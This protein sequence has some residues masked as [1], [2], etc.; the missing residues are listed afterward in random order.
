MKIKKGSGLDTKPVLVVGASGQLGTRVVQQLVAARLPVR[1]LVRAT[2]QQEHLR[3]LAAKGVQVVIGDLRQPAS[4]MAACHGAGAVIATANAVAP[5]HGSSFKNVEDQGYA[6]L[7]GACR[8]QRCGR[9]V[10]ASVPQTP[11]DAKVPLFRH[12][13]QIEQRLAASG[14]EHC[15]LRAAPFMD[16]WFAFI[17]SRLP[18]RGDPAALIHRRW[19]FLQTFIGAVGNLIEQRGI[20]LVPGPAGTR[21]AFVA[22]DDVARAL[23]RA[24]TVEAARNTTLALA[25]PQML[26]WQ[27]VASLYAQVLSRPVQVVSTPAWVFRLQQIVMRPFSEAA[28][29]LMA[30][31]AL[32]AQ[33]LPL[34]D[35]GTAALL[36]LPALT[37]AEQFLRAKAALPA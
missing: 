16:D 7:I 17:G 29:N 20:A 1:A 12:K 36:G 6:D 18:A 37:T 13:R 24:S 9:F 30:L 21:Q 10:L 5:T 15:V 25:G 11:L 8:A 4:L 27:D 31:N 14:L 33:T 23:V 26:S 19:G 28:S 34:N 22:I 2:S 3:Q 32:A 35:S